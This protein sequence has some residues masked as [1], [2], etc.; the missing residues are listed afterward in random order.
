MTV[1][2]LFSSY[3]FP[4][5]YLVT[6]SPQ[7]STIPY[8]ENQI[9]KITLSGPLAVNYSRL[10]WRDGRCVQDPETDSPR[11]ASRDYLRFHLQRGELQPL[12][13]T[14]IKFPEFAPDCTVASH[15][16]DH[17]NMCV[18]LPIKAILA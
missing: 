16:F 4:Y 18:A 14:K 5:N 9:K 6:T 2:T 15:C 3:R 10:P 12:L 17:C 11:H 7:S 1:F 13:R 8:A